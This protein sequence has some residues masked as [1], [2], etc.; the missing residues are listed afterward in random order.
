MAKFMVSLAVPVMQLLTITS[1]FQNILYIVN[2]RDATAS[3]QPIPSDIKCLHSVLAI[4][5]LYALACY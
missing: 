5:L 1:T 3:E 2:N 4:L